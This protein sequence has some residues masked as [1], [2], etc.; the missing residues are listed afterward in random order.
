VP[1]RGTQRKKTGEQTEWGKREVGKGEWRKEKLEAGGE[2]NEELKIQNEE[3]QECVL[4]FHSSC[5][6]DALVLPRHRLTRRRS[7]DAK[8]S[9]LDSLRE[10]LAE[11]WMLRTDL[12]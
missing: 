9:C 10:M 4:V 8:C 6:L 2:I 7:I 3:R 5:A 12:T 11:S 1:W